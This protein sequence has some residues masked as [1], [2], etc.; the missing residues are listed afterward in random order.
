MV[1]EMVSVFQMLLLLQRINIFL[2]FFQIV[3]LLDIPFHFT[4]SLQLSY[5]TF[6]ASW[7]LLIRWLRQ[8][9]KGCDPDSEG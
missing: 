4:G 1:I 6:L 9:R 2:S 5:N 8:A 3:F 7:T